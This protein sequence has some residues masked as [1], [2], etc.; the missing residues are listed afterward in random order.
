MT[1]TATEAP[2]DT[3]SVDEVALRLGVSRHHVVC[4]V[5]S[6][7]LTSAGKPPTPLVSLG[8]LAT[9]GRAQLADHLLN[10]LAADG[11]LAGL[12]RLGD[13]GQG[14]LERY[15]RQLSVA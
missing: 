4:L 15:G 14:N 9:V 1:A 5:K 2:R 11:I 13:R 3:Y 10:A 6:G 8:V 12:L 7:E